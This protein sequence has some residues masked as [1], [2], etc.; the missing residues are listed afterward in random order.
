M[1]TV[2]EKIE[3]AVHAA[4][5]ALGLSPVMMPD[6][7]DTLRDAI[8]PIARNVVTDDEE[9]DQSELTKENSILVRFIPQAW[10]NDH[11]IQ[12]DDEMPEYRVSHADV[13]ELTGIPIDEFDRLEHEDQM[14]DELHKAS[15]APHWVREWGGPFEI[16]I[17]EEYLD[18][19]A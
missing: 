10:I 16:E 9:D 1:Q 19:P 8:E 2:E 13:V 3:A 4:M 14:R 15:T 7:A 18:D 5:Q 11:A 6:T 12:T 17:V